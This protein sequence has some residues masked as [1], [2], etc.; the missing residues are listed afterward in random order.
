MIKEKIA[1]GEWWIG[2]CLKLMEDIPSNSVDMVLCDLP[3]GIT[4]LKWDSVI[5]FDPLWQ[6]YL[7]IAKE[8]AAF[9]F[10]ASQPFTSALVMSNA[11]NFRY[12][13]IWE[14]DKPSNF[15]LANK[16]PMKYHENI[17]VFYR[18]PCTFNKQMEDRSPNGKREF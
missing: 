1:G 8:K 17:C 5:P 3:Y 16:M 15:A 18:K 14:K 7:R 13:L 10:T 11:K 9:V 2:D 4:A 6:Q 12:E